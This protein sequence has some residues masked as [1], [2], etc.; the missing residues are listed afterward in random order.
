MARRIKTPLDDLPPKQREF[1]LA[2]VSPSNRFNASE[3]YRCAF[4]R[5]QDGNASRLLKTP[6]VQE[7]VDYI[8]AERAKNRKELEDAIINEMVSI[9][10]FN[11]AQMFDEHGTPLKPHDIPAH[12]Q[13]AIKGYEYTD[14]GLKI[15][16]VDKAKALLDLSKIIGMTTETQKIVVETYEQMME[17]L[18]NEDM[19]AKGKNP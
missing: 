5:D 16:L 1:V 2:Y 6:K 4:G 10:F 18:H 19:A 15:T 14:R 8:L 3:A 17:R 12:M 13:P 11:P 7:A 9:A